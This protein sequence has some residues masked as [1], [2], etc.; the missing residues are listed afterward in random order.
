MAYRK[1]TL[2][3]QADRIEAV[4]ARHHVQSRVKGGTVTP[5]YVRFEVAAPIGAKVRKV[6]ALAE[7]IALA[8]GKREARVYR[9]GGSI[10]VEV[11]REQAEP[12]RLLALTHRL[13]AVPP[14]TAV[15][16]LDENGTPLLVRLTAPDVAHVLIAG[17]TGSGK[18]ALARTVLTSLAMHNRQGDVQLVLVDPKG[19]GLG[20]LASLPHVLGGLARTP[21]EAIDRLRWLVGEMERR[22]GEGV[23]RPVLVVAVDELADLLQT[24]GKQVEAMLN[25]LAQRGRQAGI[26]L[27]ACTQ[28]PTA[29]LIGGALTANFPVRLVGAVASK[30]EARYAT[31][32]AD[33]SAEKL[34]GKGDFL[35]VT[36]GETVR[37]QA[38]WLGAQDLDAVK[39]RLAGGR[40]STRQWKDAPIAVQTSPSL[41]PT[42]SLWERLFG[43]VRRAQE[44]AAAPVHLRRNP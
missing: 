35:L 5:R 43:S 24:G 19:R 40:Q 31:G 8:L 38:A 18:T 36:K 41:S 29:G 20:P 27:V 25:R 9:Q 39:A 6:E 22:D 28:K 13:A 1:R 37:F 4:L 14:C 16:G 32:L 21:Q 10:Q 3:M 42:Q 30:D 11:P 7:E 12:V 17:T 33:S 26:H 44:P 34:E 2:E 15:L 23:S